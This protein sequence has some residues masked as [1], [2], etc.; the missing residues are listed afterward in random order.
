VLRAALPE[1]QAREPGW[2]FRYP[3]RRPGYRL[4]GDGVRF[5]AEPEGVTGPEPAGTF[6][7]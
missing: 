6:P 7:G 4:G 2:D 5:G 3:V 1:P